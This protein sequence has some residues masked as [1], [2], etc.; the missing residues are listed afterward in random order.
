M[1]I[2]ISCGVINPKPSAMPEAKPTPKEAFIQMPFGYEPTKQNFAINL[3]HSFKM[4]IYTLRSKVRPEVKDTFFRFY[5]RKSE[6]FLFK[7]NNLKERLTV[8]KIA[9]NRVVLV[10]GVKTGIS[11]DK[12]FK[13]FTNLQSS[14]D[15]T[16]KIMSK[17]RTFNSFSFIFKNHK[18]F[19]IK[20]DNKIDNPEN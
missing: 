10:N 13:C 7:N 5:Y 17:Q 6:L 16:I 3:P 11:R 9:D 12:F 20:F 15:D 18:L 19:V 8:G 2:F 1:L 14:L 4:E